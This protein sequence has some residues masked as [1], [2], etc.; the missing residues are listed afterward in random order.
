MSKEKLSLKEAVIVEGKYDRAKLK[1]FISTPVIETGGFRIFNDREKRR[2]ISEIARQRGVLVMTDVDSA[3]FVIR[4]FLRE[5]IPKENIRHAYIPQISGKEKRKES[6]SKEGLLG[7][8]GIDK[9]A[10]TQA[11]I[12]SGATI[13]SLEN[14]QP[15][16]EI[17]KM[18]FYDLGL[19]G[20]ENSKIK[21][22]KLL[23]SLSL[24][25]YLSAS[26][27][28]EAVNCLFSKEEFYE[29]ISK[30]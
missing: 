30:I 23:L 6:Y 25:R 24:P 2:L 10:L 26:A 9:D 21:R 8:E 19:T 1:E 5:F 15:R 4:N 20:K 3:G 22:E 12:K 28:L 14:A 13:L 27:L 7:V 18:D 29:Y 11:I 16:D 17:D